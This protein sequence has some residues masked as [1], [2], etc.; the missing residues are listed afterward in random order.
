LKNEPGGEE[1]SKWGNV[2]DWKKENK[3][4]KLTK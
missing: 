4:F 2:E 3:I 1:G